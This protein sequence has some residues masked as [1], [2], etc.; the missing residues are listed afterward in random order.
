MQNVK[1]EFSNLETLISIALKEDEVLNDITTKFF[2]GDSPNAKAVLIAKADGIL[3]G[4]DI[5]KKVFESVDPSCKIVSNFSDG[6]DIKTGD[7]ILY[8]S[9]K[10]STILS[11]E[12]TALNFIQHL[13]GIAT[14]TNSFVKALKNS[15]AKIFDTR[16]TIPAYRELAKYAVV[17]GGGKNHRMN[18]AEM[19]IIKDNHLSLI[20]D[21]P[22]QVKLFRQEYP[23]ICVEVECEKFAQ[24]QQAID[25]RADLIMLDNMGLADTRQAIDLIRKNSTKDYHPEIELSGGIK[26]DG[27]DKI[28]DL[29]VDRISIGVLTHS[30]LALDMSLEITIS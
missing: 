10:D 3:C 19:A 12:R 26:K 9:A 27:L 5:F 17:C 16:K 24:V 29:D 30:P 4:V 15:K 14:I 25:A 13:S 1:K 22:K 8:I 2:L 18:L 6:Q 23:G 20:K 21:L 11:A 28:K 7:K